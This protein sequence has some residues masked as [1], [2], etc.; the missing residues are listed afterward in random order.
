MGY[1][2]VP[3][4]SGTTGISAAA[5]R[6]YPGFYGYVPYYNSYYYD[7]DYYAIATTAGG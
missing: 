3:S 6:F 4:F 5:I 1:G 2:G 7:D